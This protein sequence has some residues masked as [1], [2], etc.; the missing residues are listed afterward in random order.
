[1]IVAVVVGW[2]RSGSGRVVGGSFSL[3]GPI[4]GNK[5]VGLRELRFPF[6]PILPS[7]S[8]RRHRR[9]SMAAALFVCFSANG[10][11]WRS[12]SLLLLLG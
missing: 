1:M 6:G 3:G 2:L 10:S 5:E 4:N 8:S 11:S 9:P 12:A 7:D